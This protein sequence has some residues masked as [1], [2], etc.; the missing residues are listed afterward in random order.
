MAEAKKRGRPPKRRHK[1][2]AGRPRDTMIYDEDFISK[3]LQKLYLNNSNYAKTA[4]EVG[5]NGKTLRVWQNKKMIAT[6][7]LSKYDIICQEEQEL[8]I[9]LKRERFERKAIDAK[10]IVLDRIMELVPNFRTLGPLVRALKS[11]HESSIVPKNGFAP[12]DKGTPPVVDP[13]GSIINMLTQ[14]L[15]ITPNGSKH[16]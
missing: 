6:L 15:N 1:P 10:L 8:A 3:A 16:D 9:D 7:E 5:V 14:Q 13:R 2:G 4:R 12:P 11:I